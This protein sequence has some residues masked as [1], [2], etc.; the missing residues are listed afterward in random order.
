MTGGEYIILGLLVILALGLKSRMDKLKPAFLDDDANDG[1]IDGQIERASGSEQKYLEQLV[2]KK[3]LLPRIDLW[4]IS[5]NK[6]WQRDLITEAE[7]L[8][9]LIA[10]HHSDHPGGY[11]TERWSDEVPMDYGLAHSLAEVAQLE[12]DLG[13]KQVEWRIKKIGIIGQMRKRQPDLAAVA[14]GEQELEELQQD[15]RD[16]KGRLSRSHDGLW[17]EFVRVRDEKGIPL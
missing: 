17:T 13:I 9:G 15:I 11:M 5:E 6:N 8:R 7:K 3:E 2:H 4:A 16:T 1:Q 14:Y 10:K 12:A